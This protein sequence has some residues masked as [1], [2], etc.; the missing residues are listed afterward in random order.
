M[1]KTPPLRTTPMR[2]ARI[3]IRTTERLRRQLAL[4]AKD[5]R[6]SLSSY[7][8]SVLEDHVAHAEEKGRRR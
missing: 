6:R 8:E 7:I 4:L 1:A 3:N 2:L 5:D